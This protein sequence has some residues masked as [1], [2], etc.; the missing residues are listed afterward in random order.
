MQRWRTVQTDG[1]RSVLF[2]VAAMLCV[3]TPL[4]L[5]IGAP[6]VLRGPVTLLFFC[7]VPGCAVAAVAR[8]RNPAAEIGL[9]VGI[10]LASATLLSQLMLAIHFHNLGVATLLLAQ[11]SFV[12]LMRHFW[13]SNGLTL[14]RRASVRRARSRASAWT[15]TRPCR[16]TCRAPWSAPNS[17]PDRS[18]WI[19][20]P[21]GSGSR[22]C[23]EA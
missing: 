6:A 3:V 23:P 14:P 2:A 20:N 22:P 10:S 11:L 4:L 9:V 18:I 1:G 13:T 16:P 8:L 5:A 15:F 19:F 12:A 17:Y 7:L 21:F